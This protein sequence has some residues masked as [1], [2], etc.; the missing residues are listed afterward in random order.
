MQEGTLITNARETANELNRFSKSVFTKEDNK[1]ELLANDFPQQ[2][3]MDQVQKLFTR[4]S[5][6]HGEH[7]TSIQI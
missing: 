4:L 1:L 5:E 3:Y 6:N 7:L 2:V